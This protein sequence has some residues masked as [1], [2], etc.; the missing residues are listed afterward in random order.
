[1]WSSAW[2]L[3]NAQYCTNAPTILQSNGQTNREKYKMFSCNSQDVY[4]DCFCLNF[5]GSN[6]AHYRNILDEGNRQKRGENSNKILFF[7]G[8]P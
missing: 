1:M 5:P 2:H 8:V 6:G 4:C 3:V 7:D